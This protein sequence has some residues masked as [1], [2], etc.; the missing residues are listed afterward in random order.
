MIQRQATLKIML[1]SLLPQ[2]DRAHVNVN[3][4]GP[5]TL[6]DFL[7]HKKIW[8]THHDNSIE[9]RAKFYNAERNDG[10]TLIVDDDIEYPPDFVEYM[11][12]KH[13]LH[14]GIVTIMGKILKPRPIKSYFKDEIIH[15][16]TF[17]AVTED[18]IVEIPGM[19]GALYGLE[20]QFHVE[21][22]KI[23]NSDIAVGVYARKRGLVCTVV[24]HP[25]NY[26]KNLMPMVSDSPSMFGKYCKDDG[27]LT[28]YVNE[29][30]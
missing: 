23:H 28:E 19:C 21:D 2:V 18:V 12:R 4:Y 8:V 26:V 25:A 30:L 22:A 16:K 10:L 6:P 1:A 24:A 29:H 7:E 5:G 14:G 11:T 17:E 20:V 13:E 9:D 3:G 27:A 15:Y